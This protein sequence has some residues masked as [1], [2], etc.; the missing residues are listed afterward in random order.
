MAEPRVWDREQLAW[1]AGLVDGEGSFILAR[2]HGRPTDKRRYAAPRLSVAQCHEG[3]LNTLHSALGF[4]TIYGPY[5]PKQPRANP[6]WLY[7][8]TGFE[9]TQAMIALLWPW[10][11]EVKKAQAKRILGEFHLFNDRPKMK[12]GV[13]PRI[14][15]C[16]PDRKHA[17]HGL[18]HSC[19][20]RSWRGSHAA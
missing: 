1:A 2:T 9:E 7:Q 3:V 11:G 15:T 6:F 20:Y 19:Y 13:I 17:A 16:H 4:G 14:S 12:S 8:I 5:K 10:L 18:C